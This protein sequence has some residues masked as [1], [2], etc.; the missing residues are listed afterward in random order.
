[1]IHQAFPGIAA[2]FAEDFARDLLSRATNAVYKFEAD[3]I[4]VDINE[5]ATLCIAVLSVGTSAWPDD[6]T[7]SAPDSQSART[8]PVEDAPCADCGEPYKEHW[9]DSAVPFPVNRYCSSDLGDHR[10]FHKGTA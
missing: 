5:L 4:S 8:K 9:V 6:I 3:A 1:M 2:G 7:S 10:R